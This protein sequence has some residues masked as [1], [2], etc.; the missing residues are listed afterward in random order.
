MFLTVAFFCFQCRGPELLVLESL[1]GKLLRKRVNLVT[2][3]MDRLSALSSTLGLRL[4]GL[5]LRM[6]P[7]LTRDFLW[8][9]VDG[10]RLYGSTEHQKYL[11]MVLKGFQRFT[12]ELFEQAMKPG[13]VVLNLGAYIGY[14]TVLA[15]RSAGS[16]G[17]VYAFEP[18]P[19]NYRFLLH[20]IKLNKFNT[21]VVALRKPA[22]HKVGIMPF[23]FGGDP[24]VNSL[25]RKKGEG[26]IV[27]VECTTVDEA[28]GKQSI[29]VIKIAVQGGEIHAL[30]GM[31]QTLSNSEQ[32]IMFV[33]CSPSTLSSAGGSVD[34]LLGQLSKLAFQVQIIDEKERCLRPVSDEIYAIR[35][36]SGKR[37]FVNLYCSKGV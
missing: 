25:W 10:L 26:N 1:S 18:D 15:A 2:K 16:S 9:E 37:N 31:E 5:W 8:V 35:N 29:Q 30:Q 17:K 6:L 4:E 32:V 27:E 13:M 3:Q 11:Y 21:R 19:R 7:P 34:M 23:F 28:L 36:A 12:V 14:Y 20:N 24:I 33:E 22:A